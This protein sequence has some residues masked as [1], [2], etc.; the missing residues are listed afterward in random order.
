[1]A[2]HA[3][4]FDFDGLIVDTETQHY[5]IWSEIFAE[6][7]CT[8]PIEEWGKCI[9]T[10]NNYFDV[11]D[12]LE[13]HSGKSVDREHLTQVHRQRLVERIT[14][15]RPRDG[16]VDFIKEAKQLG[17]PLA[18][19]SS[20]G[21]EWVGGFLDRLNLRSYF[22]EVVTREDV[23]ETKPAPDLFLLAC[24]RLG[25]EPQHAVAFEDSNNGVT[26]ASRAGMNIVAVTNPTTELMD[27]SAAHIRYRSFVDF[28]LSEILEVFNDRQV[29]NLN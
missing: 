22:K 17:I 19:A 29:V 9:G 5:L 25:V 6:Y 7:G 12:Y 16:V 20:S 13:Q 11:Y 8:L 21:I 3:F 14:D 26:A 4:V 1:M 18:V 2:I 24:S 10:Y 23:R 28:Q 15:L 27:L